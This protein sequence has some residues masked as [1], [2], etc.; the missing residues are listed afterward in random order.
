MISEYIVARKLRVFIL[1]LDFLYDSI[2][3]LQF[4]VGLV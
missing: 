4:T 2:R 3:I 1:F